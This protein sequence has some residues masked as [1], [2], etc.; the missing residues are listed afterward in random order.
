MSNSRT[1]RDNGGRSLNRTEILRTVVA[2]DTVIC[3]RTVNLR[4]AEYGIFTLQL[5][6][7]GSGTLTVTYQLA[8]DGV[9]FLTPAT[10]SEIVVDFSATDGPASDGI[11]LIPFD[12]EL[13]PQLRLQFEETS[14]S[15][16]VVTAIVATH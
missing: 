11:D 10:A 7:T 1:E 13:A 16:I 4:Q 15:D 14:S 8:H 6:L 2:D 3:P 9:H 5:V 12:L